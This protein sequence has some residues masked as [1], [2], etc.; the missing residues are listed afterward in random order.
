M[1]PALKL[2]PVLPDQDSVHRPCNH[3]GCGEAG[4]YPAPRSRKA[5]RDYT[6]LCLDHVREHNEQWN[7]FSGMNNAEVDDYQRRAT[8]WER[9][10]WPFSRPDLGRR[11]DLDQIHIFDPLGV[12]HGRVALEPK[13]PQ[14]S[15]EERQALAFMELKLP[16]TK[17][18][19]TQRFRA[20]VKQ[21]HPD[22][23]GGCKKAEALMRKTIAAYKT[24]KESK[25]L[26]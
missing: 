21:H 26:S 7:Y 3:P 8:T 4:L 6:W 22:L 10:S 14:L 12:L 25:A 16:V 23:N 11:I 1:K 24:L 20:L 5:L 13:Q 17:T 9:P 18:Q 15:D 2:K 19:L